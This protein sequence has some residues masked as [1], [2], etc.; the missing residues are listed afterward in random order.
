MTYEEELKNLK[1]QQEGARELYIK[2]QGA[3]EYVEQKIK[4]QEKEKKKSGK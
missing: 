2:C 4:E 1:L 3:I